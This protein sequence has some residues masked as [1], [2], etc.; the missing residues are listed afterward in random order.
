MTKIIF[1]S[2][3]HHTPPL[4]LKIV[5][6]QSKNLIAVSALFILVIASIAVAGAF[7]GAFLWSVKSGQYDDKQGSAMRM[8]HDD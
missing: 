5:L 3:A 2:A 6:H 1:C 7:L 8:L 4:L